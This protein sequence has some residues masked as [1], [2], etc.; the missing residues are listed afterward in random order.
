MDSVLTRNQLAK[1][2]SRAAIE[3][4]KKSGVPLMTETRFSSG[5]FA[6]PKP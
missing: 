1:T 6:D 5:V 3:T 4:S 2:D